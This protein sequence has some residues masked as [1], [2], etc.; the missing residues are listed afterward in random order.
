MKPVDFELR[1]LIYFQNNNTFLGSKGK[2]RFK[3]VP[4]GE[5]FHLYTWTSGLCFEKSE[6]GDPCDF[7]LTQQGLDAIRDHLFHLDQELS[8]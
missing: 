7:P 5:F 2:L 3:I 8:S 4:D 6:V 1:P